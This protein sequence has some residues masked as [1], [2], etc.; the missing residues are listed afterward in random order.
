MYRKAAIN[1][2]LF[3]YFSRLFLLLTHFAF[4]FFAVWSVSLNC[5]Q[6]EKTH[7]FRFKARTKIPTF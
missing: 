3:I 2:H 1:M 7:F 4:I 6:S 5:E